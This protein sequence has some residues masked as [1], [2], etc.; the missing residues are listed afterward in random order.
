M[1]FEQPINIG[2]VH[3]AYPVLSQTFIKKEMLG[4][5]ALG[6]PLRI[7]SLFRPEGGQCQG[8]DH[9]TYIL[10]HA[11]AGAL[12]L[13]HLYFIVTAPRRYWRTLLF[14]MKRRSRRISFIKTVLCLLRRED[15]SKAQRQDLLLHFLLA[16]VLAKRMKRD[17]ISFINSHFADA[18]A[19]FSLL[20]AKILG[21]RFGVTTHAY[22]IFTAPA[23]LC[24]KLEEAQFVLTCTAYNKAALLDKVD[25]DADKIQVHYH[26]VDTAKF[27]RSGR[28]V[29]TTAEILSVGRLVPKKGFDFLISACA[30]LRD[31]GVE[32]ICRIIGDGPL[33][34]DLARL[35]DTACL[36]EQVEL[37]GSL[38]P[39]KIVAYYE[40]ADIF[41]LPCVV[42]ADGDRDGIPNVIAEAMA[43]ELPVVSSGISG[44]P[45]LVVDGVTGYLKEPKDVAG[46]AAALDLLV[47]NQR[48]R[49]EMGAAGRRR[50]QA[51][52]NS[53]TCL[54]NLY[55]FYAAALNGRDQSR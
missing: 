34:K 10:P 40:R 21:L 7:Y 4:L 55:H 5:Q 19:A 35:I 30:Q 2:F 25:L 42:L 11:R 31:A 26:G 1:S 13:S 15:V 52:F 6:L 54:Q 49:N 47:R 46:V 27:R 45:E 8:P 53:E 3:N 38:S 20:T 18:A 44:I 36:Q 39:E 9:V 43:M 51:V 17:S 48:L 37:L 28:P 24:E 41:A 16:P 33:F 50:V 14:A 29:N 32:F 22:D 23:N 12:V